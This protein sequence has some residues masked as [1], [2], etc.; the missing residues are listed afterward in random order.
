MLL[1]KELKQR[2]A[3][4]YRY[5]A[6][7]MEQE[8][9]PA[10]KLFYFSIFFGETQRI[11]N[12]EWDRDLALIFMVTQQA[13]MQVNAAT[14]GSLFSLLPIQ[15]ATVYEQLT[16]VASDLATY[17]EKIGD[18]NSKEELCQILGLFAEIAY[19][20]VGNGSYLF[21]KGMIKF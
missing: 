21:E 16:Q 14:Q 13:H 5:A 20:V 15:A 7:R 17:M 2:L 9:Q 1:H 8:K 4:E 12:L 6:T 3:K 11:L 10:K 19:A 18:E